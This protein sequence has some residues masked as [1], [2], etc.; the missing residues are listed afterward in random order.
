[1]VANFLSYTKTKAVE[2]ALVHRIWKMDKLNKNDDNETH[3]ATSQNAC[4]LK[5]SWM[6]E[7]PKIQNS[8]FT[9]K[10]TKTH[11]LYNSFNSNQTNP[12][13]QILLPIHTL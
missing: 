5:L 13:S 12:H 3:E 2:L 6:P 4:V 7:T 11:K 8:Q 1:M 9:I 10:S